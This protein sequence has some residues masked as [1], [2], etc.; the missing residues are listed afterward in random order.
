MAYF[1]T[2]FFACSNLAYVGKHMQ[3]ITLVSC[4]FSSKPYTY[5]FIGVAG[6]V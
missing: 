2:S 1:S 5:M 6:W 4:V 3:S